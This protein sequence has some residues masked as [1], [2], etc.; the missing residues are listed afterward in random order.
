MIASRSD[1]P[2]PGAKILVAMSGGVDSS[3]SACLLKEQGYD[4]MG[5]FMRV[6]AEQPEPWRGALDDFRLKA[7]A[8]RRRVDVSVVLSNHFVRYALL[9]PQD[10]VTPEEELALARFQFTK[11]HGERVKSWEVRVCERLACAID[12][13]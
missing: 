6:G 13:A 11:I 9:P 7:A 4:V 2:A 8:L 10:A 3:V 1:R 5:L 12:S